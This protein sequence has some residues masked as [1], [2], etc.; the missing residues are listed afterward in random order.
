MKFR[1]NQKL[2]KTT[3]LMKKL[4][5][6]PMAAVAVCVLMLAMSLSPNEYYTSQYIPVFMERAEL[7]KSV[8]YDNNPRAMADPGKIYV[9]GDR[10]YVN[11]RYKGVHIIDNSDPRNPVQVGYIIAPGCLDMAIKENIMY[12]DNAVDF[13]AFNLNTKEVTK[14]LKE[15]FPERP[16]PAGEHARRYDRPEGYILIGWQENPNYK[17]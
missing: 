13:V 10:I 1:P 14:R 12:I 4:I 8:K 15:Y 3:L 11:E 5:F 6:I 17:K 7:E 2:Y 16:S 9:K